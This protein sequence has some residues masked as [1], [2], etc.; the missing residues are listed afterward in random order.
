M[1]GVRD[2]R[3]LAARGTG[4]VRYEADLDGDEKTGE[5][6][7]FE[8]VHWSDFGHTLA[9]TWMEVSA[10]WR[11]V[12]MTREKVEARKFANEEAVKLLKYEVQPDH[13]EKY[14]SD[15]DAFEPQA[16]IHEIWDK[17]SGKTVWLNKSSEMVLEE[18]APPLDL[19]EFFPC[20]KPVYGSKSTRSLIPVP[21]YRYYQ[22][23]AEEIDD[24]TAKIANLTGGC[25]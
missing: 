17:A 13:S 5:R 1:E 9:R 6:I 12:Y 22:D 21:D 14:G 3:L 2:D 10:V 16:K 20:P 24:L 25:A 11:V 18:G 8:F 15:A 4:W 23:Q 7:C 19:R